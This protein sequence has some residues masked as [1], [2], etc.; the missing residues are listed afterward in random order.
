MTELADLYC[1]N[2]DDYLNMYPDVAEA[3]RSGE[4][5]TGFD[6]FLSDGRAEGRK[7]Y[8]FDEAFYARAYPL[9]VG[10]LAEGLASSLQTHYEK[11]GRHRGYLPHAKATR[12]DNPAAIPSRFGGLWIDQPNARDIVTGRLETGF[13]TRT[14]AEKALFFIDNGYVVIE[15]AI[16]EDDLE[17]ALTEFEKAY[18][19]GVPEILF[20][21]RSI[22]KGHLPWRV[23]FKDYASKALDIHWF[24]GAMRDL[25]FAPKIIAFLNLLFDA[26]PLASQSLGF[27]RGSAQEAHQDSAFVPYTQQRSFAAS[28]IALEDVEAGAGELFYYPGSHRFEDYLYAGHFKSVSET[29]RA[30]IPP[31]KAEAIVRE[32]VDSLPVRARER[33]LPEAT[34]LA[35]KGDALIWHADLAHGGKPISVTRARRSVVAH[36]CPKYSSPLFTENNTTQFLDHS[37]KGYYTS[38]YYLG[39]PGL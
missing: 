23:E 39:P 7:P 33:A 1:F 16:E 12:P 34:F 27:Y 28:W 4:R 15:R 19:G 21:C 31:D 14:Q 9:A 10:E 13:I 6:H 22:A 24:S 17:R 30:G 35:K 37:G 3:K 5:K 20:E 26:K 18:S 25:I 29:V 11:V 36:Y 38:S 32:H 2:E 8:K